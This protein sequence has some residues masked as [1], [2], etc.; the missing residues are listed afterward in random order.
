MDTQDRQLTK[1]DR[2]VDEGGGIV[3]P[4]PDEQCLGAR[5]AAADPDPGAFGRAG[6]PNRQ[7]DRCAARDGDVGF[8]APR[9]E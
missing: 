7:V 8:H 5:A 4:R 2:D 6:E 3:V 9:I 1:A